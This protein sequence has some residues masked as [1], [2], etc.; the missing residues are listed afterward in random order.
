VGCRIDGSNVHSEE[1][2][3]S[4]VWG[5]FRQRLGRAYAVL[6]E[7]GTQGIGV[8]LRIRLAE[9]SEA[10]AYR[11]WVARHDTL[12]D[13]D[14]E[15]ILGRIQS[16]SYKPLISVLMPVYNVD[17]VWLNRAI[18]SVRRQLYPRWE[19]CIADDYSNRAHVR[20]VLE[21]YMGADLR[22][23]VSFREQNGH[24]SAA[25]NSA[26]ELATG[27]FVALL[28]HDDELS[29][30][31]LYMMV[32]ELNQHPEAEIVYSDEDK[33]DERLQRY[34]PN[35]KPDW[36]QDL[37]YSLNLITHL[38][39]YR[40]ATVRDI[41]GFRLGYEGSQDYDLAL[42]VSERAGPGGIR[43][44]PHVLYHWRSIPG[45]VALAPDQKNY[46]HDAAR[47]AIR[48]H[49]QRTGIAG[50]VIGIS[51]NENLHRVKY[52]HSFPRPEVDLVVC[53]GNDGGALERVAAGILERTDYDGVQLTWVPASQAANADD[54]RVKDRSDSTAA[55]NRAVRKGNR[56]IIAVI[57]GVEPINDD[58]L[59][60]M[61]G[62]ALR[63]E[64]GA[65]GAKVYRPDGTIEHGGVVLGIHELAGFAFRG[66]PAR[67]NIARALV[68]QNYSA[69]SG[70]CLVLRRQT[71]EE[72]GGF[73]EVNLPSSFADIDLCLRMRE[74]GYRILW[75]PHA[76]LC[77]SPDRQSVVVDAEQL[78]AER[79]YMRSRWHMLLAHDPHYNPNLSLHREDFG[80]AVRPRSPKPWKKR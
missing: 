11:R 76:E 56:E 51:G 42:R 2:P 34:F 71:F 8:R 55:L 57:A 13:N 62:H 17:E 5:R 54:G 72:L 7:E 19:L 80:I 29:D 6:R 10:S 69:V 77:C 20:T 40:T 23:K 68:T 63:R 18:Q 45:S 49:F 58:W 41:G 1:Q 24:I 46:A 14:R 36:N 32:E 28:D 22:V 39:V 78:R 12:T 9:H 75:T 48:S 38:A 4:S 50:E 74:R 15:A 66:V 59:E 26:L 33:I 73:D 21:K 47:R 44:V 79:D 3:I 16:L 43:H 35:F 65:V 27:E 30:H 60:E 25:S 64:I 37:F 31:A 67:R 61:V 52:T 70:G 53:P